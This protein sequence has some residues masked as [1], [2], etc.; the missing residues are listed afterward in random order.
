MG[1]RR[2]EEIM[3]INKKHKTHIEVFVTKTGRFRAKIF[4]HGM[5]N[6]QVTI[7]G[8]SWKGGAA[9]EYKEI[10]RHKI[11]QLIEGLEKEFA[12]ILWEGRLVIPKKGRLI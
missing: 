6:Y 7:N 12:S 10:I 9:N 11:S 5:P 1:I 3:D 8:R 4:P 2:Q